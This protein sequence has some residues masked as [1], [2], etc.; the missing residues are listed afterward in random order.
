MCSVRFKEYFRSFEATARVA[1][2]REV[3]RAY[4]GAT[5]N[6]GRDG[7]VDGMQHESAAGDNSSDDVTRV[8]ATTLTADDSAD[9]A[10]DGGG[11]GG[12]AGGDQLG[13][14]MESVR[15]FTNFGAGQLNS[16]ESQ[17]INS[18]MMMNPCVLGL[19]ARCGV[20]RGW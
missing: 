9:A 3:L 7:D 1:S 15:Q 11:G 14:Y 16:Q 13:Q 10:G 20:V 8:V 2:A 5:R 19:V 12:G 4:S 18:M 17:L 6:G